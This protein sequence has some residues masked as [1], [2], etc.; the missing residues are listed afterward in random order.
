MRKPGYKIRFR[1][2]VPYR[3]VTRHARR[4]GVEKAFAER[5]YG[6]SPEQ[7][8]VKAMSRG[9]LLGF[10]NGIVIVGGFAGILI[11]LEKILR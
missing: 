6:L 11:G 9:I 4:C 10:Y 5:F 3:G 2:F 1:D 8:D 7:Y